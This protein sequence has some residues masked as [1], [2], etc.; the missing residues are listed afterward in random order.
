M[1]YKET[2]KQKDYFMKTIKNKAFK[3]MRIY[4]K[5]IGI[6][7]DVFNYDYPICDNEKEI[8]QYIIRELDHFQINEMFDAIHSKLDRLNILET[9]IDPILFKYQ[10]IVFIQEL[11]QI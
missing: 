2:S 9:I 11:R 5:N 6:L 4:Q 10:I 7:Y 1:K 3:E 8:F